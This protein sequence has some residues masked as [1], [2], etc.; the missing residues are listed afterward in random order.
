M[1]ASAYTARPGYDPAREPAPD[2]RR[3]WA[4]TTSAAADDDSSLFTGTPP[5]RPAPKPRQGQKGTPAG[6]PAPAV[7]ATAPVRAPAPAAPPGFAPAARPA[8]AT[9]QWSLLGAGLLLGIVVLYLAISALFAFAQV[10]AD[11]IAYGR[12]RTTQLDAFF[13][14]AGEQAGRPTH[15]MALNLAR[16]VVIIEL[17]GGDTQGASTITGPY[18]F[19]ADEELTPIK[20]ATLDVNGDNYADLLVEVKNEQLVYINDREKNTF[21]LITDEERARL[22]P[23]PAQGGG[24][25]DGAQP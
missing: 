14:H 20:L 15:V 18:L 3:L 12:P 17:P 24:P 25:P 4:V 6:R 10:K 5:P 8:R 1:P 23:A 11:D 22:Q 7:Q 21:R 19:G 9:W 2:R 16:R 13:G